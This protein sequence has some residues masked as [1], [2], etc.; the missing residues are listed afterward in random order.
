MAN[1]APRILVI[2]LVLTHPACTGPRTD[3]ADPPPPT[4][5]LSEWIEV[6]KINGTALGSLERI[7]QCTFWGGSSSS[8][9]ILEFSTENGSVDRTPGL[10]GPV[11]GLKYNEPLHLVLSWSKAH[12]WLRVIHPSDGRVQELNLPRH[13]WGEHRVGPLTF[14]SDTL[15]A[16]VPL[17]YGDLL[18]SPRP[19]VPS[20]LVWVLNLEGERVG[21]A[22][23]V[24]DRGGSVLSTA[25]LYAIGSVADTVLVLD[26]WDAELLT[27][28]PPTTGDVWVQSSRKSLPRYFSAPDPREDTMKI[29]W[30]DIGGDQPVVYHVPQLQAGAFGSK[31]QFWVIRNGSAIWRPDNSELAR[32]L[33][34]S[35]GKWEVDDQWIEV[36]TD[37]GSLDRA[38]DL[39]T[40]SAIGI[41]LD[42][43]GTPVLKAQYGS[44]F[45]PLDQSTSVPG[46]PCGLWTP[47]TEKGPKGE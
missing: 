14:L 6:P 29:P 22:G 44:L 13:P 19:W 30:I 26:L 12:P 35:H 37:R 21:T 7:A 46:K 47:D 32:Q 2:S 27:F 36:Y 42:H 16:M 20:P 31:G 25:S 34:E 1:P 4:T 3:Q 28:H 23:Q 11:S 9:S 41:T 38:Y 24:R 39:P 18:P 10:P 8:G 43:Y 40:P 33:Y 5:P 45:L 17:G 15:I